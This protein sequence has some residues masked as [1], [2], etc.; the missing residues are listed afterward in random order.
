MT[1]RPF[2]ALGLSPD[3][4]RAY[5][6]LVSTRGVAP[7]ELAGQMGV[8]AERA[9]AA[10][11]ELA[12]RGLARRGRDGRW[13]P[14]P[15]HAGFRPLLSRAQEQLRAGRELLDRLDVEYQ[16]VHQGHRADEVVQVVAGRAAIRRRI[17]DVR[18]TARKEVASFVPG[19][20]VAPRETVPGGV[21]R[22]VVF[23]RAGLEAAGAFGPPGD[24]LMS[25][26]VAGRLP[27][28][29]D[30]ADRE[31]ALLPPAAED[32]ADPVML[33]VLPG[34]LLDALTALF[35]AVWAGGVPLVRRPEAQQPRSALRSRILAMLVSG[36][37]DAAMARSLGV[38]VRTVQRHVAAMQREAGVDNRIQL[39]W[40]AARHG[41][42]DDQPGGH[43][44]GNA[45]RPSG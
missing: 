30:I 40:H 23:E 11:G 32:A 4:D 1:E 43:P 21:R 35:D 29:L 39:V 13:Y 31:V 17:E 8:S 12:A 36:S 27:A 25:A 34:P 33:V 45:R 5:S 18:G 15:P 19:S 10:C 7:A 20:A 42:L 6:L 26:R 22:R 2:E 3:A 44:E 37:T 14:V 24:P 16:R 9:Q 38:A 41:W 28:R